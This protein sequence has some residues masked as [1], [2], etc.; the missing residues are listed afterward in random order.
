M[1]DF[2]KK[3]TQEVVKI[4]K[5]NT[6][7][8]Y[9]NYFRK[10]ISKSRKIQF[11]YD[12]IFSIIS[13]YLFKGKITQLTILND[14]YYLNNIDKFKKSFEYLDDEQSK[15]RFVYYF[16]YKLVDSNKY[17]L[18]YDYERLNHYLKEVENYKDKN[19]TKK[20]FAF[21]GYFY[22]YELTPFNLKIYCNSRGLAINFYLEQ[23]AYEDIIRVDEND[24]VIDC[25]GATGDTA[26]YFASKKAK[27]V[28]VYEFIPSNLEIM[29][30]NIELN[31]ELKN[32]IEIVP[33]SVWSVS[34]LEMSY[35][36][37]GPSSKVDGA[38][39]Y[40]KKVKTKSI[41]DLKK[42]KN[43]E[44]VDF[45]KMDIEGAEMEALKG[46][47]KSISEDKPKLA[48]CVYH[49]KD[50]LVT[51]PNYIKSLN[52]GY[53]FYFDYYTDIGWEAVLYAIDRRAK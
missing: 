44:K 21:F 12:S 24:I 11:L 17:K 30:S 14:S 41:D 13:S 32:N 36:D 34:D 25:G 29:K 43:I 51:I 7:Y 2:Y 9:K 4:F 20:S 47:A 22:F 26:L 18:P 16:I 46:A 15:Q 5:N 50:D 3:V 42:N 10:N 53:E 6:T 49:K 33:N 23:Y 40:D 1:S 35:F 39:V 52:S 31:P 27:K 28:F 38:S 45:I 19:A 37:D 48:I 8:S